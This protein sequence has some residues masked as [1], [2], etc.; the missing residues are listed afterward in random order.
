MCRSKK[1]TPEWIYDDRYLGYSPRISH[2]VTKEIV[3]TC[4]RRKHRHET[5]NRFITVVDEKFL[6]LEKVI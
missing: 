1:E 6:P 5:T 3:D 2:I 4:G